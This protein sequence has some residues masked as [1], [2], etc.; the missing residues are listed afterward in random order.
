M[1]DIKEIGIPIWKFNAEDEIYSNLIVEK[2][3]SLW[4]KVERGEN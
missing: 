3:N 2:K 4:E 1:L